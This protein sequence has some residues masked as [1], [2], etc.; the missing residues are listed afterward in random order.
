[1]KLGINLYLWTDH[2]HDNLM[3]VLE[4]LK[5]VWTRRNGPGGGSA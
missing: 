2:M 1:M 3:P 4:S 5:Q